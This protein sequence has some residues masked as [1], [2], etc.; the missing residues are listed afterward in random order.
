MSRITYLLLKRFVQHNTT[1][2]LQY[3]YYYKKPYYNT[4]L[5]ECKCMVCLQKQVR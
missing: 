3:L 2:H 1:M 5:Q 4:C